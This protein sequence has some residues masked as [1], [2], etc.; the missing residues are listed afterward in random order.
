MKKKK[1]YQ[2]KVIFNNNGIT[3]ENVLKEYII[4]LK[5]NHFMS[6]KLDE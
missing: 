2:I 3:I 1:E 4:A 5:E 6:N